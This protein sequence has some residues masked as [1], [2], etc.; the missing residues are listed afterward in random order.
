MQEAGRDDVFVPERSVIVYVH[1]FEFFVDFPS[2]FSHWLTLT[3][4]G[5]KISGRSTQQHLR[6]FENSIARFKETYV[7]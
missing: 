4:S 3:F 7:N 6:I 2:V 5:R 1:R